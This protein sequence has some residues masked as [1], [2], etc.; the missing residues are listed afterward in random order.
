MTPDQIETIAKKAAEE[1]LK[2]FLLTLG[3]NAQSPESIIKIQK[4]FQYLRESREGKEEVVKK[5]KIT[6]VGVFVAG[7]IGLIVNAIKADV[8]KWLSN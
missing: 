8:G 1:A 2:E 3:A 4:D 7:L 6:F 5:A